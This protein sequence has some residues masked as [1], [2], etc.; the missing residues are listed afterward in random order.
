M[1]NDS[2]AGEGDDNNKALTNNSCNLIYTY[3]I[4]YKDERGGAPKL[5]DLY[6]K[7][8]RYTYFYM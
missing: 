8:P 3:M 4:E 2:G 7:K 1:V 5:I 6:I